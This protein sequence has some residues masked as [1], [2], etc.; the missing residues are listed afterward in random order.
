MLKRL[1]QYG[2]NPDP[3]EVS[4]AQLKRDYVDGDLTHAEFQTAVESV[5]DGDYTHGGECLVCGNQMQ[6]GFRT[7]GGVGTI[8]PGCNK[9]VPLRSLDKR[10]EV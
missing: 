7:I 8:C 10:A 4:V 9:R 5:F 1:L 6:S 3:E 2:V